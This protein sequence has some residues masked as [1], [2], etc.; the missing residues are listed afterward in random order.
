V[1]RRSEEAIRL[2]RENT[3]LRKQ[4]ELFYQDPG[5]LPVAGCGDSSCQVAQASG[6]ST[7]GGCCCNEHTLRRALAFYKRLAQFRAETIRV[8]KSECEVAS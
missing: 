5:D 6:M 3:M 4:I 1:S 7:N 8:M 2:E